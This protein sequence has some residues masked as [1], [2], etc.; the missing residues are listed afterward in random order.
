MNGQQVQ[1]NAG[2]SADVSAE[3]AR[4]REA[5]RQLKL[6][7]VKSRLLRGTI[8]KML[9][10]LVQKQ[11]SPDVMYAAFMRAVNE[12]QGNVKEFT[13]LMRDEKS[14]EVFAMAEKSSNENPFGI[15]AWRHQDHPNWFNLD[16]DD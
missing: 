4:L 14:K 7:H 5:M 10:P 3:E 6:L 1:G 2:A 8:P 9:D 13:E 12:A 16:K 11:P 15:K